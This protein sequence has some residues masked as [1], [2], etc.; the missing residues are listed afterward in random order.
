MKKKYVLRTEI[1]A[2][3]VDLSTLKVLQVYEYFSPQ[4]YV[5]ANFEPLSPRVQCTL[6][7]KMK[8]RRWCTCIVLFV[9]AGNGILKTGFLFQKHSST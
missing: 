2:Q 3:K 4:K 6:V 8:A 5:C 1:V 9:E 7:C